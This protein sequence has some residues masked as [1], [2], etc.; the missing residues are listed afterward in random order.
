MVG[1]AEWSADGERT[2]ED[3]LAAE[4]AQEYGR[5]IH[6]RPWYEYRFL[7]R[8]WE[9]WTDPP[10]WGEHPARSWERKG[11]LTLEYGAKAVY[12]GL[13]TLATRAAYDPQP[14]RTELLFRRWRDSLGQVIP[15]L[16][17]EE[18]LDSTATV[19]SAGRFDPTRDLLLQLARSGPPDLRVDA[20]AGR[21]VTA[22]TGVAPRGWLPPGGR[23]RVLH[24]M[25]LADRF[26]DRPPVLRDPHPRPATLAA[27]AG[28][29]YCT[30]GR[31]RVRLSPWPDVLRPSVR[32]P[33]WTERVW[34]PGS[35]ER[36]PG[37]SPFRQGSPPSR[38]RSGT[39]RAALRCPMRSSRS[40][41]PTARS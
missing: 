13:I 1:S 23:G 18:R 33:T 16:E 31:P 25:P 10:L 26:G 29:R 24:A 28:A 6:D 41:T 11:F 32:H 40:P 19:V 37:S 17:V 36:S 8:L 39:A 7:P 30:H 2:P 20:I 35:S 21:P 15:E 14:P 5:F 3:T 34:H 27:A 38:E 12:A 22:F 4:V 9:V